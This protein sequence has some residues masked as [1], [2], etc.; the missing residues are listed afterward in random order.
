MAETLTEQDRGK[1]A[2]AADVV[3][4]IE[5]E[6]DRT[7]R[8]W[9]RLRHVDDA[10]LIAIPGD[11]ASPI[12]S[13]L[14][15]VRRLVER[16][17]LC[18]DGALSKILLPLWDDP[19]QDLARTAIDYTPTTDPEVTARLHALLDDPRPDR[20]STAASA[21]A[22]SK[23][24]TILPRL[25]AWFREGDR[26]HRNVAW[27]CLVFQGL[28]GPDDRRALLREAWEAGGRDD[29]DRAMLAVGLLGRGDRVGW[30]FLVDLC[31]R[32]DDF[33]ACWAAATIREH[34]PALGLDLIR[35]ILDHG[36]TFEVRWGMAERIAHA[37]SLPHL[38][39]ADGLAEARC[40]VEQQR[41]ALQGS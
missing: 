6:A 30:P 37:A 1:L 23:D 3:R 16:A 36:A 25:L 34:D 21:L 17:H 2:R 10:T 4:E 5:E 14:C 29:D 38:W 40:W 18:R 39:T 31:R 15:A 11:R 7:N 8:E 19:D 41:L 35:H 26:D 20:W 24:A 28:L 32:A 27:S 22:M 9:E 12:V 33:A 13:R